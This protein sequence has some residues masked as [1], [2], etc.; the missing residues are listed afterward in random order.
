MARD[1]ITVGLVV[2]PKL[3]KPV[4]VAWNQD[5]GEIEIWDL[6]RGGQ[7]IG[8]GS[9][10]TD[11]PNYLAAAEV[12]GLPRVH[13]PSGVTPKGKGYGT[14]LYT[15]LCL[16]AHLHS[17][18]EL[19]LSVDQDGDGVSS[20]S[21]TRSASADI[22]WRRAKELGLA[23]QVEEERTQEDVEF[24][25]GDL[26]CEHSDGSVYISWARGDLTTEVVADAYYYQN[27]DNADLIIASFSV[28]LSK[29]VFMDVTK[30][31]KQRWHRYLRSSGLRH[32]WKSIMEDESL[33]HEIEIDPLL[34]LD[35][36]GV[37]P[38]AVNLLSTL[39]AQGGAKDDDIDALRMRAELNLDP[40]TPIK[41]MRL[42]FTANAPEAHAIKMALGEVKERREDLDWDRLSG[43][44]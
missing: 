13:T 4:F 3:K 27:A 1:I 38:Q 28:E 20:D 42:A 7:R 43:L 18:Q 2:N 9:Y 11:D 14:T 34:A 37:D 25:S 41:Q 5:D 10:E 32:V 29:D 39:A 36:R 35:M 12:T 31:E 8:L 21:E 24:D 40:S 26:D 22:W 23:D 33:V 17:E 15:G 6:G 19:D 30:D 16:G 44:P